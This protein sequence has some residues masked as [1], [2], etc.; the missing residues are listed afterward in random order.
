MRLRFLL[1]A[2]VMALSGCA[3]V[4]K[5]PD[6]G[7]DI[8]SPVQE[9]AT[10]KIVGTIGY[11]QTL[12]VDYKNPP[13]WYSYGFDGRAG[14]E[15]DVRVR[16][17]TGDSMVRILDAQQ[18]VLAANDDADGTLDSHATLKLAADG[19]YYVS[20][21]DYNLRTVVL[22]VALLATGTCQKRTCAGE[23]A[24]CGA[25]PDG[26]GGTLDCGGC[27]APATCG[28]GGT[29]NVCG[30]GGD[31]YAGLSEDALKAK[32]H[33]VESQGYVS[34]GYT[35]A[36]QQLY[37]SGGV[38]DAGG[39]IECIYTGALASAT[40]GTAPAGF[41]TEHTWPASLGAE[42]EPMHSDLN[43]LFPTTI[44]SNSARAN[45]Y[46]GMTSC[47]DAGQAACNWTVGGS[48]LGILTGGSTL[49]FEVRPNH[50]GDVAR[51][52]FYFS[53]RYQMAIPDWSETILRAW[54]AADPPDD[55]ER[56]RNDKVEALQHTRN[57][58]IDRPDLVARIR[59]F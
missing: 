7:S 46:Y 40:T 25:I 2:A 10:Y 56:A 9:P 45:Y 11:G 52:W 22:E 26:C 36:R 43:H 55:A 48:Q 42:S 27:T 3:E 16:S 28:G 24:E 59:D 6:D 44:A 33:D 18:R 34:L 23:N 4:G 31:P 38:S 54:H 39:N 20:V 29:P 47:G 13:K 57:V 53:T 21:R 15:L 1:I 37:K 51:A 58:F 30:A 19:K 12:T 41:N 14:D 5:G 35:N 8:D 17:D 49:V 32:I 50:R